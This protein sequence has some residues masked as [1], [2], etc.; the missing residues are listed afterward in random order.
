M[1]KSLQ[2]DL[3]DD[4]MPTFAQWLKIAQTDADTP[5][6]N[7]MGLSTVAMKDGQPFPSSRIVLLKDYNVQLG[8]IVFYTNYQSRKAAE[9]AQ[10]SRAAA[11]MHW[12]KLGM[13]VRMEG[14]VCKSPASESDAYFQ[15]RGRGSKLG[16]WSSDQSRP[17]ESRETLFEK[18]R[19]I[20]SRFDKA[21]EIPRPSHWG[22]Y[23]LHID[24]IELWCDGEHRIHDRALW[25]RS[26][27]QAEDNFIAGDWSHQRLQP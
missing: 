21:T 26:L 27:S 18:L 11:V 10:S 6:F 4:P 15:S 23:R 24:R 14:I 5:N 12:D 9:L 16:A 25:Q 2:T 17:I 13:Q 3:P 20:E 1:N 19:V 22:G 7:S 8:Y